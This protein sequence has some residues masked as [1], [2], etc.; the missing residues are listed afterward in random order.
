MLEPSASGVTS[1]SVES[2]IAHP[3]TEKTGRERVWPRDTAG[4]EQQTRAHSRHVFQHK[5]GQK[6]SSGLR[7]GNPF[8]DGGRREWQGFG[9]FRKSED[10]HPDPLPSDGRG[11]RH[12]LIPLAFHSGA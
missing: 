1:E 12:R 6:K 9:H 3:D 4:G 8:R 11:N 7:Y 5:R 2:H 10:P